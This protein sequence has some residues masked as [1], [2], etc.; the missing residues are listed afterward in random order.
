VL[1]N[2][3]GILYARSGQMDRATD[4]FR[5][6][7]AIRP[8]YADARANLTKAFGEKLRPPRAPPPFAI[9]HPS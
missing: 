9:R 6:A 5:R 4:E 1:H 7:V 8:D 2:Q 3:L